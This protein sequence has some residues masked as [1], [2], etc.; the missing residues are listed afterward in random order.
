MDAVVVIGLSETTFISCSISPVVA[1]SM[2]KFNN[3]TLLY[4]HYLVMHAFFTP[5][6]AQT[7]TCFVEA[8]QQIFDREPANLTT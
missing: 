5:K 2:V 8:S 6:L 1:R 3:P 4:Y 7:A